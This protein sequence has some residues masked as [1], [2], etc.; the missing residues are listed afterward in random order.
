MFYFLSCRLFFFLYAS[1]IPLQTSKNLQ[2]KMPNK[3]LQH[4]HMMYGIDVI[5]RERPAA[6][7]V[8]FWGFVTIHTQTLVR[9]VSVDA[10]L[11]AGESG[12]AFINVN[13]AFPIILQVKSWPALTLDTWMKNDGKQFKCFAPLSYPIAIN[14]LRSLPWNH[15]NCHYCTTYTENCQQLFSFQKL[16]N[17]LKMEMN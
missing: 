10:G 5:T 11:T 17:E 15:V 12:G 2:T 1:V 14:K 4:S 13:T 6:V 7:R 9:T 3:L 16:L 8:V